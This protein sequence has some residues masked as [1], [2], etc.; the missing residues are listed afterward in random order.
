[1]EQ[2]INF[3][4]HIDAFRKNKEALKLTKPKKIIRFVI[5]ACK[6]KTEENRYFVKVLDEKLGR[7]VFKA[8]ISRKKVLARFKDTIKHYRVG[9]AVKVIDEIG[10]EG[11]GGA[12][13]GV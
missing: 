2:M 9:H 4:E 11:Y 6:S 8:N 13:E 10:L 1:M 12:K 7:V 5:K 3:V